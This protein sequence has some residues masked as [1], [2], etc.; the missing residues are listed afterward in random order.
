[1]LSYVLA[2]AAGAAAGF[3]LPGGFMG[4]TKSVV[5]NF[6]LIGLLFF[7]GV[8]LGRDPELLSKISKFGFIS[9]LMSLSVVF[10]SVVAV[11]VLIRLFGGRK[12]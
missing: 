12:Q 4:K 1:M 8:N 2:L 9:A 10:F 7:M 5:F 11:V 3:F 6:A